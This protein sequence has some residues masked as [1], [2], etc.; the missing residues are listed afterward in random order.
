MS[1]DKPAEFWKG[2]TPDL[3][4]VQGELVGDLNKR[5]EELL[6]DPD[7][8]AVRMTEQGIREDFITR[9]DEHL[10]MRGQS[11]CVGLNASGF[12]RE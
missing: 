6:V 2:R 4:A 9:L 5:M 7:P 1:L 10:G 12:C 8:A 11:D 3:K